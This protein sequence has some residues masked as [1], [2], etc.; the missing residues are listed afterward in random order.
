MKLSDLENYDIITIQCHD[1]PDADAMGAGFGLYTYFKNRS[2]EVYLIYSGINKIKKANLKLMRDMLGIPIKYYAPG[3]KE[4][5]QGLLITVDCQYG[6]GNVTHFDADDVAIIDHHPMEVTEVEKVRIIPNL[7]SCATLVWSMLQEEEYPVNENEK[8]G[9]A[10]YYGL[11]SDTNQF[12]E[13]YHPLDMDMKES[14]IFNKHFMAKFRNSNLSLK[15]L[16]IAGIAMIRYDYNDDYHFAVIKA[17][18]CDPNIL[19]LIS[20]FLLQVDEIDT[21]VVYNE[22]SDGY[23]LSVRSCIKEV[24]ANELAVF[25]TEGIGSG[26]GH[27]EKAGGF[28]SRKLY[29]EWYPDIHS[30]GYFNNRMI[31]YFHSFDIVYAKH[32]KLDTS[33]MKTYGVHRISLCYVKSSDAEE[34][35]KNITIRNRREE[36]D[37]ST[38]SQLYFVIQP[39]GS[40]ECYSKERFKRYFVETEDPLEKEYFEREEVEPLIKNRKDGTVYELGKYAKICYTNTDFH[41]YAEQ[42]TKG[43]KVFT[44][45]DEEKYILGKVGD[46]ITVNVD[47]S[48]DIYIEDKDFFLKNYGEIYLS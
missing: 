48:H 4:K 35:G 17:Q 7:G 33:D 3:S 44:R 47:D 19:G 24:N 8:L 23:K 36:Y 41:V 38:D 40:M 1:N 34:L 43:A 10:L 29:E 9:T 22:V 18:P 13:L 14:I 2:K 25:L 16:E 42:L 37:L 28:I 6:A 46:Y 39:D 20:D 32:T 31:E 11:C 45:W 5:I 12:S 30:E 15:E 26:G 21:C 27:F